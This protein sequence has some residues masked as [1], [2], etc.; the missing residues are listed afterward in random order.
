MHTDAA[1]A[2]GKTPV[3]VD[4]LGVDLLSIAGHKLYAPKGIGA[5]YIR[6]GVRLE[7]CCT[8][9]DTKGGV[10]P[11]P[12]TCCRTSDWARPAS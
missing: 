11:A 5:L 8:A 6:T 4:A 3:D 1:Q 10:D 12:K 9:R 7:N 2:V